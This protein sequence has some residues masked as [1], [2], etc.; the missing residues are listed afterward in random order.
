MARLSQRFIYFYCLLAIAVLLLPSRV[1]AA[2]LNAIG[3]EKL[4]QTGQ[5]LADKTHYLEALDLLEEARDILDNNGSPRGSIY[6]D[7]LFT[8]GQTKIKARLHQNFS[9]YYVK[10]A[11]HDI[12]T[13][14]KLRE[15]L[16]DTAP[17]RLA[18]G[19]FL[20]GYI[21]KRFFLRTKQAMACFSKALK[22]YPGLARAKRELAELELQ[23]SK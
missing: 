9:A 6:A 8:L 12:Q 1:L 13:A 10:T 15:R 18:E 7:V 5:E 16:P 17:Q 21:Q 3:P 11:L 4:L 2:E 19:L 23:E 20:E 22:I 14:N